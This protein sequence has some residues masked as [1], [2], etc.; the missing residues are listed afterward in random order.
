MEGAPWR[1]V[2]QGADPLLPAVGNI[3]AQMQGVDA[4]MVAF[5]VGPEQADQHMGLV[6]QRSVVQDRRPLG[7]VMHEHVAD[8]AAGY[9]IPVH[10]L[11]DRQLPA[12]LGLAQRRR[13]AVQPADAAQQVVG[14]RQC[15]HLRPVCLRA[16]A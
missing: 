11:G 5:Q 12:G 2:G 10:Q 14:E 8:R 6:V 4:G 13:L 7:Q 15:R 16:A 1:A 3:T 9:R